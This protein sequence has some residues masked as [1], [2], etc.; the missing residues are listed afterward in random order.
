MADVVAVN[1]SPLILLAKAGHLG[2]LRLAAATV[3]VPEAVRLEVSAYRDDAAA[4]ALSTLPWL[5][6]APPV[7]VPEVVQLWDLGP[8][9]TA[10]L[11]YA[12]TVPGC[13]VILDDLA[14]RRCAS[15]L[16]L[17]VRGTLG[18]ALV[19]KQRG[20]VTSARAVVDDLRSAGMYLSPGVVQHA[21]ALVGE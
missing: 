2:L 4:R 9:E 20:L 17:P 1:S 14:G 18:L 6:P 15:S 16:S 11:A 5:L 19:A 7:A 21:L 12:L 3:V 13:E 10:V 8:G